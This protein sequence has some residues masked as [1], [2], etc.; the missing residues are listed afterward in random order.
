MNYPLTLWE[1]SVGGKG[2]KKQCDYIVNSKIRGNK[3]SIANTQ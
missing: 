2:K 3:D 1:G